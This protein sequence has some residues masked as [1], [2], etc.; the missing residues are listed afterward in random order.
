[1]ITYG[2]DGFFM[3]NKSLKIWETA[4]LLTLCVCLCTAVWAQGT[5][6]SISSNL[7]R[8]HILAVDDSEAEQEIK[9]K[10]R[11]RVLE[12]LSPCLSETADINEAREIIK[13]ELDK[14]RSVASDAA[15]GRAVEVSLGTE[16]YP[17]RKYL[18]FSL[19]AGSYESLKI[20]LG[21]AKGHNWWCVVFPPV[22]LSAAQSE[23]TLSTMSTE[24]YN[25]LTGQD[26]YELRFRILELWGRMT[27]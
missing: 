7:I 11:D 13:S 26:G 24:N 12:Y 10:V 18:G 14:L 19:P 21:E 6:R 27:A 23:E 8:L 20:S 1:M 25:I 16:S 22:C 9:L 2:K 5:M 17:T 3:D 15:E 4:M